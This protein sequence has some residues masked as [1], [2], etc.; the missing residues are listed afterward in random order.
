MRVLISAEGQH[1]PAGCHYMVVDGYGFLIDLSR[2]QGTL[3]DP[4]IARA[5]WGPAV[6]EGQAREFGHI[7]QR[8]GHTRS[9]FDKG[10]LTPYLNAFAARKAELEAAQAAQASAPPITETIQ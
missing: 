10:L 8:D 9:F 7:V 1:D 3:H 2:V 5:E 6:H 4:T